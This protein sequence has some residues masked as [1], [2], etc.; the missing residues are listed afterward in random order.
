MYQLAYENLI[1]LGSKRRNQYF[2]S[3]RSEEVRSHVVSSKKA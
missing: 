1:C 2:N 3:Y